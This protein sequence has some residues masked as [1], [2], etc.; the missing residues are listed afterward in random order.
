MG[1]KVLYLECYSGISG[2]MTVAALL[3]LTKK[4]ALLRTAL[5]SLHVDGYTIKTGRREKCGIDAA[6]FDVILEEDNHDHSHSHA[7][8]DDHDHSHS[9]EY[10]DHHDY[11]HSHS[12]EQHD[13][14]HNHSHEHDHVHR[15]VHDIYGIIE[16]S[17]IT[18][19]AKTLAKKVFAIVADAEAK[20]HGLPVEKVHFHEVGAVDS[21]VD[22]VAACVLVDDLG[23]EDIVVSELHEGTGHV[24]CQHGVIPV[25]VPATLN[26]AVAH[27]LSLKI[28]DT[29]GEMITPTGA[30]LAAALSSRKSLPKKYRLVNVG[31]GSGKKNFSH[32]NILRAYLL[33]EIEEKEETIVLLETNLDDATGEVL[34]YTLKKL[35]E[36]GARDAFF[37]P[38]YMKK[39]R[40]AYKLSVLCADEKIN[41]MEHIIFTTTTS[42]GIRRMKMERTVLK[43]R[44][45]TLNTDYGQ[46]QVKGTVHDGVESFT[47][48]YESLKSI[49]ENSDVTYKELH[50]TVMNEISRLKQDGFQ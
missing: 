3:D 32:A 6:S 21:I 47:P 26:I 37:T 27:G 18:E 1:N 48:E 19:G 4:D 50:E 9:H 40:P 11:S 38:I 17:E 23:V 39:N 43:R 28:T 42:I 12:H 34:G 35:M 20:A 13:H 49:L 15:N 10:H 16:Q 31:I 24:W 2:D 5:E 7:H 36:A 41:E 25:P 29:I 22:I 30:A 14:S 45:L 33:E 46:I 8:S 44:S